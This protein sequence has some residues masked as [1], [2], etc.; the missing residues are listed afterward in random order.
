MEE[1]PLDDASDEFKSWKKRDKKAKGM[2]ALPLSDV[3]LEQVQHAFTAKEMWSLIADIFEK[4]TLLNKLSARRRFY[5]AKMEDGE[6]IR[7]FAACLRQL[8]STL[9]SI[10]VDVKDNEMAMAL[11]SGLPDR[12][13]GLTSALD[14]L[15]DDAKTFTL[16]FVL[17]RV[18]QE[19][20]RHADRDKEAIVKAETAALVASQKKKDLCKFCG[21]LLKKQ[22]GEL[23]WL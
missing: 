21:K 8:A 13:D 1:Q 6:K 16:A 23:G 4:H 15:V 3:H 18:K 14:A 17:V 22:V 11:L 7:S 19:E 20:R 9:K 12:F 2:I 5:T 10:S